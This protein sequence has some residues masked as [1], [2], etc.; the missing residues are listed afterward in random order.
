MYKHTYI[1]IYVLTYIRT[2]IYIK[3][4]L[5]FPGSMHYL[6]KAM[7]KLAD[8][9]STWSRCGCR[10]HQRKSNL[11]SLR[12]NCIWT[13]V[14]WIEV[15]YEYNYI[16]ELGGICEIS[17][18]E[19]AWWGKADLICSEQRSNWVIQWVAVQGWHTEFWDFASV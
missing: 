17:R 10:K 3:L 14:Q 5:L 15:N 12:N 4:I 9:F 18:F 6:I 7:V 1:H 19:M 13:L 16:L 11:W 2:Y 8:V